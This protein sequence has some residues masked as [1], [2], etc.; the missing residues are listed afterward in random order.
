MLT[1]EWRKWCFKETYHIQFTPFMRFNLALF[2]DSNQVTQLARRGGERVQRDLAQRL[3]VSTQQA[4]LMWPGGSGQ[5]WLDDL[6]LRLRNIVQT[7]NRNL[8]QSIDLMMDD[9]LLIFKLRLGE[10][11]HLSPSIWFYRSDVMRLV[12]D[13][14]L[15]VGWNTIAHHIL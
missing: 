4:R 10:G 15:H 6:R 9:D 12:E 13:V 7:I 1:S 11:C 3:E 5:G 14:F 8:L 2:P